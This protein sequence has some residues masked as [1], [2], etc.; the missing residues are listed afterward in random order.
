[1]NDTDRVRGYTALI[2]IILSIIFV[3]FSTKTCNSQSYFLP[4]GQEEHDESLLHQLDVFHIGSQSYDTV[5][6]DFGVPVKT[7]TFT[8]VGFDI[9]YFTHSSYHFYVYPYTVIY[10]RYNDYDIWSYSNIFSGEFE[11]S[12]SIMSFQL[13]YE[14]NRK[15]F[16]ESPFDIFYIKCDFLPMLKN[17]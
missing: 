15:L 6:D 12:T 3:T 1:M 8:R 17:R 16:D 10:E 5:L 11:Y 4:L 2:C 14:Y 7:I 9:L 13:G